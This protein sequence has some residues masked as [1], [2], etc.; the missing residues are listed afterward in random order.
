[1]K[2][3]KEV[4]KRFEK[5]DLENELMC[6]FKEALED[7]TFQ[8][9]VSKLKLS[10]EELSKYTSTLQDASSEYAHCLKC[11]NLLECKNKIEGHA[12]LPE[13]KNG[14]LRFGYKPCK[15]MTRYQEE[16]AYLKNVTSSFEPQ[17]IKKARFEDVDLTDS[18]RQHVIEKLLQFIQNY[19]NSKKEKGLYLHGSFGSGKT[20]LISAMFNELA[21]DGV[22]SCIL[23]WPEFLTDLK[24]NFGKDDF[25]EKLEKVK[26]NSLLLIDDIGAEN[27]TSW[28]RDDVLCPI[29]QYRM[30][31][32]L[33]TFFT[34]NLTL[35]ELEEHLSISRDGVEI[36]KAKRIMERIYQLTNDI[37]LNSKNLRK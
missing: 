19:R 12:F 1:M 4:F 10:Y 27:T 21:K 13:V 7:E 32:S 20:F 5:K 15:F 3:T 31:E 28:S 6:S 23:F 30:Q 2:N 11:K 17:E 9:L 29:L 37:E 8:K 24:T 14:H 33:P 16:Y 34:S 36:V 18:S 35:E 26:K 25:K 22:K